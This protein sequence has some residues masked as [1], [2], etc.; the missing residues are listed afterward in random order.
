[1]VG[2]G[3]QGR[4]R[5]KRPVD[6]RDL[7]HDGRQ[8]KRLRGGE[9]QRPPQPN[10]SSTHRTLLASLR[11]EMAQMRRPLRARVAP[12]TRLNIPRPEPEAGTSAPHVPPIIIDLTGDDD[13]DIVPAPEP[14]APDSREDLIVCE[15]SIVSQPS[16][17]PRA[18]MVHEE[19]TV[20][21][22]PAMSDCARQEHSKPTSGQGTTPLALMQVSPES[23]KIPYDTC[24]G[25][26]G[27]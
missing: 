27:T 25:L 17:V 24:F 12:T 21:E 20:C 6:T 9:T 26:V 18:H 11:E 2:A 13:E 19:L 14:V 10:L 16:A 23:R 15:K 7:G 5:N 4:E 1:M 3:E 8:K 22:K